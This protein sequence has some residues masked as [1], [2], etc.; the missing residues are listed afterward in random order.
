MIIGLPNLIFLTMM[1]NPYQASGGKMIWSDSLKRTSLT[2][3]NYFQ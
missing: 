3:G 2:V 1:V